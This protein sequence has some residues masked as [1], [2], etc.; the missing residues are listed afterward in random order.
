MSR[1]YRGHILF[2]FFPS[3]TCTICDS[4][5]RGKYLTSRRL[6]MNSSSALI[7]AH[8][9]PV[10]K[11]TRKRRRRERERERKKRRGH[12]RGRRQNICQDE[13]GTKDSRDSVS[14]IF[15]TVVSSSLVLSSFSSLSLSLSP[16]SSFFPR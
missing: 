2:R 12:R 8:S 7:Q 14:F 6:T 11:E 1:V 10:E 13:K 16:L 4:T 5:I 3:A 15:F 9:Q